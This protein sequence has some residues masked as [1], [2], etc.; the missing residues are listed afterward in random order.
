VLEAVSIPEL[1]K[2]LT[3]RI[4]SKSPSGNINVYNTEICDERE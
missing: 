3:K 4:I 1:P 2:K